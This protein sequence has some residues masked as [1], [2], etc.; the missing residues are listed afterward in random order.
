MSLEGARLATRTSYHLEIIFFFLD[1]HFFI[2]FVGS[3]ESLCPAEAQQS[4]FFF[5]DKTQLDMIIDSI[6]LVLFT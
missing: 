2:F 4:G 5:C 6:K 1:I 3:F